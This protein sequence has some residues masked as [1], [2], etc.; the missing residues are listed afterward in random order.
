MSDLWTDSSLAVPTSQDEETVYDMEKHKRL[1]YTLA[2]C[3][4]LRVIDF[5]LLGDP[6]DVKMF[7]FTGWSYDE[8]GSHFS[9][10]S[11]PNS[12]AITPAIA[13]PPASDPRINDFQQDSASVSA[14]RQFR[15][16]LHL[17]RC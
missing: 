12:E 14:L 8:G 1:V 10:P 4:S 3:H 2:T 5:E 15:P 16:L 6:L 17:R 11:N 13:R 9:E 7:Q